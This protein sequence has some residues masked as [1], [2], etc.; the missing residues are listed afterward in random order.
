MSPAR[1]CGGGK[2]PATELGSGRT[3]GLVPAAAAA[4]ATLLGD[5]DEAAPGC[6]WPPLPPPP[7]PPP[8][9]PVRVDPRRAGRPPSRPPRSLIESRILR[10]ARLPLTPSPQRSTAAPAPP[11]ADGVPPGDSGASARAPPPG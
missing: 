6:W 4:C 5:A 9:P 10:P 1:G 11:V 2:L 8:P 7:P 3:L